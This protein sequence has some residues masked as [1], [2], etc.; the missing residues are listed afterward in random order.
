MMQL[1][2]EIT[3]FESLSS[4]TGNIYLFLCIWGKDEYDGMFVPKK[5]TTL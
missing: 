2:L 3:Q 4:F 1:H 5:F